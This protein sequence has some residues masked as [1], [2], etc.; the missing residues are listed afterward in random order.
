MRYQ[1]DKKIA[2]IGSGNMGE[3]L[4][5]GIT[6]A[7]VF[8][9]KD[10]T[11][12][13][14]RRERLEHIRRLYKVNITA[15]NR[16]VVKKADIIILS[17]KPQIIAKVVKEVKDLVDRKKLIITIAAGVTINSI[18]DMLGKKA[19]IVRVMPNTPAIVREGV[20]A[21]ASGNAASEVDIK[22][23][24]KIFNAVGRTV[25]VEESMMDAVTG[26][27]GSGPAYVFL[28][29]ESLTDAGVNMGLPRD[30]SKLLSI[31]TILGSAK[32]A[33]DTGEH[34]GKLKD[35]V[36]SPGGTTIAGLHALEDGGLR[37]ALI[38]AV[39]AAAKRSE[40]LG[41]KG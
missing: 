20:S 22:M 4:I 29:I 13:D 16:D 36:T 14:I 23:A 37:A 12:T 33:L 28:I 35:M 30:V 1:I 8:K 21:I 2:F 15:D 9:N 39:E 17:V 10:I 41:K 7:G 31:Q 18:Q 25:I 19:R 5:K 24:E 40:E 27:S 34:P 32:L 11:V 6:G 26:L 3:A 38:N